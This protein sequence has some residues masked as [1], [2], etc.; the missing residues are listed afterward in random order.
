MSSVS[1][2]PTT[3]ESRPPKANASSARPSDGTKY[4]LYAIRLD[5]LVLAKKQFREANPDYREGKPC[6]CVGSSI[7]EPTVRFKKH[8]RGE[9]SSKWVRAFGKYV[10]KSKCRVMREQASGERKEEEARYA[11]TLRARG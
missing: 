9:R 2:V 10:V 7:Y 1:S 11:Q 5:D 4:Y 3:P 8:K 6:Y